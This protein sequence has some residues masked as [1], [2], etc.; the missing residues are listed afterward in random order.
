M[1]EARLFVV[2]KFEGE[3]EKTT[4]NGWFTRNFSGKTYITFDEEDSKV[5]LDVKIKKGI[6]DKTEFN[7]CDEHWE[8]EF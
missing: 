7:E 2:F 3:E 8:F 1:T 6:F 4:D 5:T